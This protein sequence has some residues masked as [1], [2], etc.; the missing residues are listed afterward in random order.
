MG[1]EP[2]PPRPSAIAFDLYGTL[3]D[4]ASL[5]V[6]CGADVGDDVAA[7][8]VNLWRQKQL[9]YTWLRALMNRYEDFWRVTADALDHAAARLGL[10][11]EDAARARVMEA[12]L[13][14][15]PYPEV[16]AALEAISALS[17]P[18]AIVSNGSP[19]M[20]REVL[21]RAGL[22]DRFGAVLSVDL[23]RTYKPAPAVYAMAEREI[24]EPGR[25]VLFVSANSWDVAGAK[26]FGFRVALVDRAQLVP[27]RLGFTPDIMVRDV[28]EIAR[29]VSAGRIAPTETSA[30]LA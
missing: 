26:S 8:F 29:I 4:L 2:W 13:E 20:L 14:L 11:L 3:L 19:R 16:G 22:G 6:A 23:V 25:S 17:I 5:I 15:R 27:E 28:T 30:K 12:W 9:E 1:S 7:G 18:M 24:G 21:A 10:E